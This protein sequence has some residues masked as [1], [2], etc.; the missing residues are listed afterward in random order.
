MWIP[1]LNFEIG[2]LDSTLLNFEK[3][4]KIL[5]LNIQESPESTIQGSR[6][7]RS[8]SP[9]FTFTLCLHKSVKHPR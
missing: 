7:P 6:S 4:R 1:F 8:R 5:L 2:L 3:C 9:G